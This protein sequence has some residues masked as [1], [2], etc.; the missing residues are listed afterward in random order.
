MGKWLLNDHEACKR[1]FAHMLLYTVGL[2]M[3][4]EHGNKIDQYVQVRHERESTGESVLV[5]ERERVSARER[6]C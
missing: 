2:T 1:M 4:K 5:R 3:N 6:A